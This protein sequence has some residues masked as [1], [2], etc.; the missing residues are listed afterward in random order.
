MNYKIVRELYSNHKVIF[1]TKYQM[2]KQKFSRII[3]KILI[4]ILHNNH[5]KKQN[6]LLLINRFYS[7][8]IQIKLIKNYYFK[9]IVIIKYKQIKIKFWQKI[10]NKK[11]NLIIKIKLMIKCQINNK[12]R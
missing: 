5:I 4:K 2:N 12:F 8:M 7:I 11:N 6:K 1:R 10:K 9:I 3:F